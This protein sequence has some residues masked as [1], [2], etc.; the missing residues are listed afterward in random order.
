MPKMLI[1]DRS[2]PETPRAPSPPPTVKTIDLIPSSEETTPKSTMNQ[3][4]EKSKSS[5]NLP[6]G[7]V[8]STTPV[9]SSTTTPNPNSGFYSH[10]KISSTDDISIKK[11]EESKVS[12]D[13][14]TGLW[15]I[16]NFIQQCILFLYKNSLDE[17]G[18][19]LSEGN[20]R[21]VDFI[22]EEDE[23][24]NLE[25]DN[26][27]DPFDVASALL[28]YLV[29][30]DW[31][32]KEKKP[33]FSD[34][35]DDVIST[36]DPQEMD[37]IVVS[38]E[39]SISSI[40]H[41]VLCFLHRIQIS[42]EDNELDASV[43]ASLFSVPF[44]GED[45]SQIF[46]SNLEQIIINIENVFPIYTLSQ[47]Y[48]ESLKQYEIWKQLIQEV[49][50]NGFFERTKALPHEE[51]KEEAEDNEDDKSSVSII[52][53]NREINESEK[54]YVK[55]TDG[56][57][58]V[59]ENLKDTSSPSS[60]Y[61]I[62]KIQIPSDEKSHERQG[63]YSELFR[64]LSTGKASPLSALLE[65]T[66]KMVDM[67]SEHHDTAS[68]RSEASNDTCSSFSVNKLET[69]QLLGMDAKEFLDNL[70]Q[71]IDHLKH[72]IHQHEIVCEN[73]R[74]ARK[75]KNSS[76][77]TRRLEVLSN[78]VEKY[79]KMVA[80]QDPPKETQI[81]SE[82]PFDCGNE[83]PKKSRRATLRDSLIDRMN[84]LE[85]SRKEHLTFQ[86]W[87]QRYKRDLQQLEWILKRE[88]IKPSQQHHRHRHHYYHRHQSRQRSRSVPKFTSKS[89]ETSRRTWAFSNE[90]LKETLSN[91]SNRKP[92]KRARSMP[93]HTPKIVS[94]EQYKKSNS[95][96]NSKS[97]RKR[98]TNAGDRLY[99]EGLNTLSLKKQWINNENSKKK[100]AEI[101]DD[102]LTFTPKICFSIDS[103]NA[104][105]K[106]G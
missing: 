49:Y 27:S 30:L 50:K 5:E 102:E 83:S 45:Q 85:N 87:K 46:A 1:D 13:Q 23:E 99:K 2:R 4:S 67:A 44:V 6:N 14:C 104:S 47:E 36:D 51:E 37:E 9:S 105:R 22:L 89:T 32:K 81:D 39:P 106:R 79:K 54:E 26:S 18:L 68:V 92:R 3:L 52:D 53:T 60:K 17:A 66:Q 93:K 94:F 69:D 24:L 91:I 75:H 73:Q 25:E 8:A 57:V 40:G 56:A 74:V 96:K 71:E 72:Q 42:S 64:E 34:I 19:F 90:K 98:F 43:L 97:K 58:E 103:S 55:G 100:E 78:C 63:S 10:Q 82:E 80:D 88:G 20:K 35:M 12:K 65:D 101:Y 16:P 21:K 86:N 15:G 29:K 62:G 7:G 76:S 41:I 84:L 28:E 11:E 61:L 77:E 38:L 31:R 70:E 59:Y 33:I 48:V 95:P